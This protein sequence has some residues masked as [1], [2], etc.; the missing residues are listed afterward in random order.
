MR[1]VMKHSVSVL[2]LV[3]ALLLTGCG[4]WLSGEYSWMESVALPQSPESNQQ[5]FASNY[6]QLRKVLEDMVETGKTQQTISVAE[7]PADSLSDDVTGAVATVQR[8]NPIAAY[9]VEEISCEVGTSAGEPVLVIQIAY[10]HDQTEIRN[11]TT[12]ADHEAAQAA[13]ARALA[14][15]QTGIVL[16]ILHYTPADFAQLVENYALEHPETVMELPQVTENVYPESGEARVVELKLVYQTSRESLKAMQSQ[17]S[18]VFS[19][20]VLYVSGD[21]APYEK[22]SQLYS[23]LMERFKYTL[24]TSITPAY[25]LLRHGVG[26][27]KAFAMVY[28]A[29]CRQAGLTCMMVSGT[30]DGESHYWNILEVEGNYYHM[31]LLRCS[32]EGGFTIRS[33]EEMAGYV[34]DY[35]A[36]PACSGP[37]IICTATEE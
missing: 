30:R 11:I 31:D 36:Y 14:D 18:P 13:I 25:S 37:K 16:H 17:V 35:S 10:R 4:G 3:L 15:C 8:E 12:V 23:F 7:Y 29:M 21:G 26:D 20:A 9:A 33:D 22:Y 2:M 6:S 28:S 5:V 34:W 1:I 19:S 32:E 24:Q 27:S